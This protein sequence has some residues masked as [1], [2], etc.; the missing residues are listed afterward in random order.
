MILGPEKLKEKGLI[1]SW[2][3][4]DLSNQFFA[5]NIVSFYFPLWLTIEKK[6]PPFHLIFFGISMILVAV[7]APILGVISDV[8]GRRKIF[9]IC[10]TL[11]SIVFT[12]GLGLVTNIFLAL[13]FFAIANF[14]CQLAVVF[15]SALLVNIAP[16]GRLGFVSGLGRMFGYSGA[17]LALY[18]TKPEK[19][20]YPATFILTGVLFLFFSLPCMIFIKEEPFKERPG[21]ISFLN[22]RKFLEIFKRI[23]VTVFES[24]QLSELKKF[25]KAAFFGL[26]VVNTIIVIMSLYAIKVFGLNQAQ[27]KSLIGVSTIFAI[28]ASVLVGFISDIIGYRNSLLGI[29]FLWGLCILGAVFSKPPFHWIVGSLAGFSL[30]ATWVVARAF[31]IKIVPPNMVGE[32]F[33]LF[34]LV[35]YL[36]A[37]VGPLF[38]YLIIRCTSFL[39]EWSYRLSLLSLIVFIIIS[40]FFLLKMGKENK[41]ALKS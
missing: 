5:L 31:V 14:G 20:G 3:L 27:V 4:Y 19:I 36:S 37:I 24:P 23:K 28:A 9:L 32:A 38:M 26:C 21:F 17:I 25:L 22:K 18:L 33:G 29:F 41:E 34:N 2:A 10:F 8:M 7:C 15:Y 11:L 6:Y 12:I 35:G 1:L 39:G 16:R 40:C 30:G 13:A